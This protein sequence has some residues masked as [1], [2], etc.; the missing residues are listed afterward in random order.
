MGYNRF[1]SF[2]EKQGMNALP[3]RRQFQI[4]S[5]YPAIAV[6]LLLGL[7]ACGETGSNWEPQD[8]FASPAEK[9]VDERYRAMIDFKALSRDDAG[10]DY[11]AGP[12]ATVLGAVE[13]AVALCQE[14]GGQGCKA[15]RVGLTYVDGLDVD[16]IKSVMEGYQNT[17]LAEAM[18]A[19]NA[20]NAGAANW[21]AFHYA[22]RG[23]NLAE[24]ERLIKRALQVAPN[25]PGALDTYG[26]VLYKQ[27]KYQEAEDVFVTVNKAMPTAEHIAHFADNALAMGK[28]D[29]ARAAYQRALAA[30]PSAVLSQEIQKRLLALD[31]GGAAKQ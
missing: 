20:G 1:G 14:K 9:P 13:E 17:M 7:S 22:T 30:Q 8:M 25:D 29:M 11:A 10:I 6:A 31:L 16:S 19:A 12:S 2:Y 5:L 27:G 18:Q 24:A 15:V 21:L 23:E 26:L 28:T 3:N 4:R